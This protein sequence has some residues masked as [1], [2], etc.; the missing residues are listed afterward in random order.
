MAEYEYSVRPR[1][2][3]FWLTARLFLFCCVL[4]AAFAVVGYA[5]GW[6][7][8]QQHERDQ[9]ATI[10]IETGKVRETADEAV[11]KGKVL[12]DN[13]KETV[14]DLTDEGQGGK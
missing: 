14:K 1:R 9:K 8:F 2:G 13:A 10:E 5:A 11:E 4:I 7:R 6:I 12:L 3:I